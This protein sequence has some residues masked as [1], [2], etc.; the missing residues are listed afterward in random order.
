MSLRIWLHTGCRSTF[1]SRTSARALSSTASAG[2]QEAWSA[3]RGKK[4]RTSHHTVT[5]LTSS[6]ESRRR[7]RGEAR[8]G[9]RG[10]LGDA[11]PTPGR[12]KSD[13]IQL[14]KRE[15]WG[16]KNF[17]KTNFKYLYTIISRYTQQQ[18]ILIPLVGISLFS[19]GKHIVKE[20]HY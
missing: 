8:Q 9:G 2:Q 12:Q 17:G 20:V 14:Q 7:R 4:G 6:P 5:R 15:N 1:T 19:E 16:A 3:S 18:T 10:C 11:V 13:S